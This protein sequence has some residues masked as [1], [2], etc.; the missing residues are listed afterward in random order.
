MVLGCTG[1]ML[2]VPD[3]Q[4]LMMGEHPAACTADILV[5]TLSISH[6]FASS[7]SP[8]QIFTYR[9]PDARGTMQWSGARQPSCSATSYPRV[10]L[11]SA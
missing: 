1:R 6:S 9:E 3:S 7:C 2:R 11:P 10:L 8:F 4:A 5:C